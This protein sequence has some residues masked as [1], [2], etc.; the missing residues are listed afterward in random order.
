MQMFVHYMRYSGPAWAARLHRLRARLPP[1]CHACRAGPGGR[2]GG[3]V[4]KFL[5]EYI[6]YSMLDDWRVFSFLRFFSKR[7]SA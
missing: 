3:Q 6:R 1:A 5:Q 7:Y 2:R 4:R